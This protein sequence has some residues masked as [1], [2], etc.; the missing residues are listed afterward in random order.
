[1]SKTQWT[2]NQES[3]IKARGMQVLVSAAAGS[4]K[5]AVLTERAKNIVMDTAEPC[6]VSEILVVTFT[7]AAA[8]EMKDRIYKAINEA[9]EGSG[10]TNAYL[11]EQLALL[12]LS[13]ICTMDAFCSKIVKENFARAGVSLDFSLLDE[14]D[15]AELLKIAVDSVVEQLYEEGSESFMRLTSMLVSERN[16]NKLTDIILELYRYSRSYPSPGVWLD[17]LIDSFSPEKAPNDTPWADVVYK[18]IRLFAECYCQ[19]FAKI[20]SIIEDCGGFNPS[21]FERFVVTGRN[22]EDL[23]A[24]IDARNWDG[25]V[26]L[27]QNGLIYAPDSKNPKANEYV[28]GLAKDVFNAFKDDLGKIEELTLP[29]TEQHKEDSAKLLPMVEKLCQAVKMLEAKLNELKQERNAYAFE[30][31][32]HKCIDLLVEFDENGWHRTDIA[33]ALQNKYKEIFIDEYQDTNQAQNIIF[34]A[35]SKDCQNLYCVGDV[36]QSIYK[37]RLA[38]PQMFMKLR[39][40]LPDYDGNIHPS[41]ITLDR[42]FR[43][44]L[45]ITQVTNHLFEMLMSEDVGEIDYGEKEK[46]VYGADYK[47]K[48]TPDVELLCL[49]YSELNSADAVKAEAEQIA[50]YINRLLNSGISVKTKQGE[51]PLESSDI[52]ILLRGVKNKAYIYADALKERGI[53]VNTVLDGDTS[54]SK[55]IQLLTSFIK[56]VN[57]PLMDIPLISVL[58]SPLYGFTTDEL[59]EIR[60]IDRKAELYCCLEKYAE[61][62]EKAKLFLDKIRLYRNIAAS[63]PINEFVRFLV[64]DSG[65]ADIFFAGNDGFTRNANI[66]GFLEFAEGFTQSGR[67]GLSTFVRSIDNAVEGQKLRSYG[68]V[69]TPEGVQIMSIHKSK[70]LEFPY[71][72]VADCSKDFNKEDVKKPLKISRQTG[73]GLKI[74]DDENFTT[75]NTLCSVAAEKEILYSNASEEL[76]VLYVAVTRAKEHITFVCCFKNRDGLKK[77]IRLNNELSMDSERKVNPFTVFKGKSMSEWLLTCFSTHVDCGILCDIAELKPG[78]ADYSAYR[79]DVSPQGDCIDT[80]AVDET[81][82]AD[83]DYT[84]LQLLN[85]RTAFTYKYDCSGILAKT[86][87]SSTE[88]HIEQRHNF[89][90]KKPKFLGGAFSGAERGTA[91]H[92]F[93]EL[94]NFRN[95]FEALEDEKMRLLNSNQMTREELETIETTAVAAFFNSQVGQRLLSAQTVLREY[96]FSFLKKAGELYTDISK[97]ISDEEIVVRGKLDCAFIEGNDAVLIDYKSDNITDPE[98]YKSIYKPQ[99]DIYAQALQECTG[100]V[101]KECY[102]YSFKLKR[103]IEMN[104]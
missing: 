59:A 25:M 79:M 103:F 104:S 38:S 70:G 22:L 57:N 81:T 31:I 95:A 82:T 93:F 29:T 50:S 47:P 30:D 32:M 41:Q 43:S 55:E 54:T 33:V 12:P 89:A 11:R 45:G 86:T 17:S 37:F 65:I 39:K 84:L 71:V 5:T 40:S 67:T 14:K 58:F 87:A 68:G 10:E 73:I 72:I 56:V 44:R 85:E 8:G 83:V 61:K 18:H 96:E 19:R 66:R 48:D 3:A 27:I 75:Y 4:G 91:I 28:K 90:S 42:N 64:K 52:C 15:S 80:E 101:V 94:C 7:R 63:Y 1:M 100:Y 46:L 97:E 35:I 6:G 23:I 88:R 92:K 77:K 51:K 74:R 9:C 2:P 78:N 34:E 36:K 98:T 102:I 21:I 99:L 76:R 53:S 26:S 62:S 69:S 20:V 49:D 24:C 13:D 16:D 60:M